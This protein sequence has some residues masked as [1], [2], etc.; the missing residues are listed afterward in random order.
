MADSKI[1][2]LTAAS[3]LDGTELVPCVQGGTTK[4]TTSA[5]LALPPSGVVYSTAYTDL[6]TAVSNIGATPTTLIVNSTF[7]V[8]NN[9]TVPSTLFLLFYRNGSLNVPTTKTVTINGPLDAPLTTNIFVLTGTGN[10][11][12]SGERPVSAPWFNTDLSVAVTAM[13][14]AMNAAAD[15]GVGNSTI[16]HHIYIPPGV[17]SPSDELIFNRM[18][19]TV[20]LDGG[21]KIIVATGKRGINLK[22]SSVPTFG[23]M[24][25]GTFRFYGTI[26]G[27]GG[28]TSS[29]LLTLD[30][31][32]LST[33][34]V[35]FL[36]VSGANGITIIGG[37]GNRLIINS[38]RSIV[39]W[40]LSASDTN[41]WFI[42]GDFEDCNLGGLKLLR[43]SNIEIRGI[44]ENLSVAGTP[45]ILLDSARNNNIGVHFES[46]AGSDIKTASTTYITYNNVVICPSSF[47]DQKSAPYFNIELPINTCQ[48]FRIESMYRAGMSSRFLSATT[49]NNSNN[50]Q[51]YIAPTL[52]ITPAL[53]T[54]TTE[55]GIQWQLKAT[56][57]PAKFTSINVTTGTLAAGNITGA[58][59]TA[60]MSTNA[61]P[62]N[63]ATRTAAQMIADHIPDGLPD[64][65][66]LRITNT[67]AG[68]FTLTA[69]TNVTLTGT[70]TVLLNTWRDFVVTLDP[71]AVTV[72][73][74]S[75]GIGTYT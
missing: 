47:G 1:S 12:I 58:K 28:N 27:V 62:G 10:V 59:F 38:A 40:G 5:A 32:L 6:D 52:G 64:T 21:A 11:Y 14:T 51:V 48:S 60:L 34:E 74:Q 30:A 29:D 24:A 45:G 67:G 65:Y 43:T 8:T 71:Y 41:D 20:T 19:L 55:N 57:L 4:R 50:N 26:E 2:A 3:A 39:G 15:S 23:Y 42:Y 7:T 37:F 9:V 61:V 18:N 49:E 72:T 36:Y 13:Q 53:V 56:T 25:G 31:V 33:I 46:N 66:M 44:I 63:Q 75:T 35:R 22:G 17:Y 73:I 69:G 70:M 54:D 68:T 16:P